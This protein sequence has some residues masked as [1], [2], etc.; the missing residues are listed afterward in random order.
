M[1]TSKLFKTKQILASYLSCVLC[2]ESNV[3]SDGDYFIPDSLTIT[4]FSKKSQKQAKKDILQFLK[5]AV[6]SKKAFAELIES[7][8]DRIGH[9]IWLS[10]NG[11]GAGFFDYDCNKLQTIAENLDSVLAYVDNNNKIQFQ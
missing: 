2:T 11:Y 9:D 3:D 8:A 4:D 7:D 10:R 6:Q 5:L 1:K